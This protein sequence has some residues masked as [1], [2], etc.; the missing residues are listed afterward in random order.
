MT[1]EPL[2]ITGF[3]ELLQK[4]SLNYKTFERGS[5]CIQTFSKY[6]NRV[7]EVLLFKLYLSLFSQLL[8]LYFEFIW[9]DCLI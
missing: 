2:L 1:A 4:T 3:L 6:S 8:L 7:D 5:C 9:G